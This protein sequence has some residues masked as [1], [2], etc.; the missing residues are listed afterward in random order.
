MS[1]TRTTLVGTALVAAIALTLPATSAFAKGGMGGARGMAI[2]F[3]DLD[4][5]GDGQLTKEEMQNQKQA[6]FAKVDTNGDG[7]LSIEELEAA[8]AERHKAFA[9]RM[10]ERLDTD[11]NGTL[12]QEEMEAARDMRDGGKGGKRHGKKEG[13]RHGGGDRSEARME[14]MFDRVDADDDGVITK[15]EFDEAKANM[16]KRWGRKG[17]N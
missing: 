17:D 6:R 12:S 16:K 14:R 8:A 13:K 9:S 5:N 1:K 15:A 4:L 11:E 10:I 2:E 7:Q 3:E